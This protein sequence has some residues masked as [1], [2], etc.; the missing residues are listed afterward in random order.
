[1]NATNL[2]QLARAKKM[3]SVQAYLKQAFKD[4]AYPVYLF[5]SYAT[6]QFHGH[7]DVDIVIIAPD[8]LAI[9]VYR[10]ACN[11]MTALGMN[12]DILVSSSIN[13]LDSS[14][15]GSLQSINEPK[16]QLISAS[17]QHF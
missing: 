5:G 17:D 4:F 13:R 10:Q 7:S 14:I 1:M 9:K 11:K 6:A 8:A 15:V 2:I 16:I 12:Y 3:N